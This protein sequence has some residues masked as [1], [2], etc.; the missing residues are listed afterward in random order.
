MCSTLK[1]GVGL[2]LL[3]ALLAMPGVTMASDTQSSPRSVTRGIYNYQ[4]DVVLIQ[5]KKNIFNNIIPLKLNN[6]I[7]ND[8][9]KNNIIDTTVVNT[10]IPFNGLMQAWLNCFQLTGN[11]IANNSITGVDI[12]N[13]SILSTD[14]KAGA[15]GASDLRDG[16]IGTTKLADGVVT[17]TKLGDGAVSTTKL[18]DGAVTG[19]KLAD[20]SVTKAK[21]APGAAFRAYGRVEGGTLVAGSSFG[22]TTVTPS[23]E[24]ASIHCVQLDGVTDSS[25]LAPLVT[26]IGGTA[27]TLRIS[28]PQYGFCTI[29]TIAVYAADHNSFTIL[30][31]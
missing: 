27:A 29:S 9:I 7:K 2:G 15:V 6:T 12:V 13:N 4:N 30:V 1:L 16:S 21:L 18:A 28:A 14:I 17:S 25:T 23:V 22:I 19:A 10:I 11:V 3:V 20:G 24:S 5:N 26:G 8:I 31:P